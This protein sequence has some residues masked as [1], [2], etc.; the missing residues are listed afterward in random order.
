MRRDGVQHVGHSADGDRGTASM[1]THRVFCRT[2]ITLSERGTK[3]SK[4]EDTEATA[5]NVKP[6][7]SVVCSSSTS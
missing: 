7:L 5:M 1:V 4:A 6:R 3:D 2:R